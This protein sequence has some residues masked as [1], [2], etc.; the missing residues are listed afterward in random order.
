MEMMIS[1]VAAVHP[2]S[3][4][5]GN[6]QTGSAGNGVVFQKTLV[7]QINGATA[8]TEAAAGS[9]TAVPPIPVIT[10]VIHSDA[11]E[12]DGTQAMVS[13]SDLMTI[14]D[15]LLVQLESSKSE[16]VEDP[17]EAEEQMAQLES[18]IE[19]MTALLTIL[20]IPA[21]AIQTNSTA[22]STE[23]NGQT[24]TEGNSQIAMLKNNLQ[25]TLL[26][27]QALLQQGNVKRI[28]HIEP[29]VIVGKQLEAIAA[30][31]EGKSVE[32]DKTQTKST[33]FA[34]QLFHAQSAPPA[35]VSALLQ[36]LSQQAIHPSYLSSSGQAN[37]LT[38]D[39]ESADNSMEPQQV[40]QMGINN[41]EMARGAALA[42]T[43]AAAVT[44]SFVVAD[45][46]AQSMTGLVIQKFN[47]STLNGVSE[48][49]LMLFPEH[50][51]QVDVRITMQN[52]LLTAVFQTD[53]VMAKDML[54]N[55]MAQLR[56]A[57]QA[58]GLVVDKLE[59]S[60]GQPAAQLFQ[61]QH[62]QGGNQQRAPGQQAFKGDEGAAE[63]QFEADLIEQAA[64]QHL[65]YGR[66]INVK[67]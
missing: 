4:S 18:A 19:Q 51:G 34:Q 66:G 54:D 48:A 55:Q 63:S 20:G 25:D 59:V 15:G 22:S 26:Q 1:Q 41:P 61:Q 67:A 49:K 29:A 30:I 47:I 62:G 52:G 44:T 35:E 21:S 2:P 36:R 42:A 38:A 16:A 60:Q 43:N 57:L 53:N 39:A 33:V 9:S 24:A 56:A 14:I 50:L 58:Q 28:Q 6:G 65:G 31:L 17:T 46:F 37:A 27:L 32:T 8:G 11:T 7:Q 64:V 10:A 5:A 40:L 23:L 3:Q 12:A 45:D 13:L